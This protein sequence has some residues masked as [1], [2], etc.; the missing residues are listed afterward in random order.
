MKSPEGLIWNTP[1]RRKTF[2]RDAELVT[3]AEIDQIWQEIE[4]ED[5]RIASSCDGL[6]PRLVLVTPDWPRVETSAGLGML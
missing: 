3:Q 5:A 2:R 4:A 6:P 1:S